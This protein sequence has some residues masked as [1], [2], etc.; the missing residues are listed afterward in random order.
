MPA[1]RDPLPPSVYWRRRAVALG[2]AVLAVVVLVWLVGLLVGKVDSDARGLVGRSAAHHPVSSSSPP[3]AG[4]VARASA[5]TTS[6]AP[7]SAARTPATSTPPPGPPQ[8][9][10]DAAVKVT[11]EVDRAEYPP[12][13]QPVFTIVISNAGPAPCIRDIGRHLRDLT[14]TSADGATRL[15]SSNDCYTSDATEVRI[16][17]P[18]ERFDYRL[19]WLGTTTAPGCPGQHFRVPAGDYL[20]TAKLGELT[21]P[22]TPFRLT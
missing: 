18:G 7:S 12:G 8:P 15:W 9:C 21:S 17:R 5:T 11:A 3:A 13:Q 2:S 19:T 16:L 20:L 22:P 1:S 10:P 14:V 4:A 6:S